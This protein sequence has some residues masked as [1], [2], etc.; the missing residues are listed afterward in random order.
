MSLK[1]LQL[2][3]RYSCTHEALARIF[4]LQPL[5]ELIV[6]F[7]LN[8]EVSSACSPGML[9]IRMYVVVMCRL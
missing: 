9:V 1:E 5:E 4:T 3:V 8:A 7:Y 6:V 2:R